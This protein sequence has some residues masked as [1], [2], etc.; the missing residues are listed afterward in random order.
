MKAHGL[1]AKK[2]RRRRVTTTD[3][4]HR[5]PVAPN[6]LNR[7]FKQ[8]APN[9]VWVCDITCF[10][11]KERWL[12]LAIVM[13]LFSRRI[14]GWSMSSFIDAALVLRAL[15]MA[16]RQRRPKPGLIVHSDRGS[17][18]ACREYRAYLTQHGLLASMS[19]KRNC[20]DN[21]VAESFF[22]SI[23]GDLEE[24]QVPPTLQQARSA[25]FE[26]I[27]IWYNR[28]RRHSTLGYLSPVAFEKNHS[29]R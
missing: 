23:K 6:L 11:T 14:V 28:R 10:S 16:V 3:S 22:A 7:C 29:V 12:Y 20:W 21:A 8:P 4:K 9:L 1:R 2:V 18:Y 24:K 13:D 27:E 5:Y 15:D 19:R 17:Q 26:Y 25:I